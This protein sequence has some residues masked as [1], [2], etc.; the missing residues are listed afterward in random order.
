MSAGVRAVALVVLLSGLAGCASDGAEAPRPT[1]PTPGT[2]APTLGPGTT[3]PTPGPGEPA[4]V[5]TD[6][7]VEDSLAISGTGDAR[8]VEEAVARHG[9]E[10][11]RHLADSD[12]YVARF[13]V[14]SVEELVAVRDALR[15]EGIQ[16][17]LIVVVSPA[18]GRPGG[19]V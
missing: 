17:N 15:E 8:E 3:A 1:G 14:A 2:T 18:A 12:T 9:G 5:P 13:D 4:P 11:V 6:A 19:G 7:V 10:V 16:A